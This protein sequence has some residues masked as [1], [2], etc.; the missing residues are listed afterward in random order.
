MIK[1]S[2]L[3]SLAFMQLE[4]MIKA[5]KYL[6]QCKA[7]WKSRTGYEYPRMS[8]FQPYDGGESA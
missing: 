7:E 3:R 1:E 8:K 4:K 5:G 2:V 6:D